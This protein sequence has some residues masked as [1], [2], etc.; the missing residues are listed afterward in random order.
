[1]KIET[2]KERLD[3]VLTKTHKAT[4]KNL[5]LPVL[6]CFLFKT[7]KDNFK[8]VATNLE[9]GVEFEVPVKVIKNGEVAV[10]ADV[11]TSFVSNLPKEEK[12]II[13]HEGNVLKINTPSTSITIKTHSIDDFPSIP[14]VN[15]ESSFSLSPKSLIDGLRSVWSSSSSSSIKPELSSVFM[16][17]KADSVF[18]V[19]T[20]SFRLAEKSVK[21]VSGDEIESVLIPFKN[22][23]EII[24]VVENCLD[25]TVLIS[26]DKNQLSLSTSSGYLTSRLIDG[27]FP[28]YTQII[29]KKTTTEVIVLKD[30]LS[31]ALKI[32]NLFT[33]E[34][35]QVK[36]IISTEDKKILIETKNVHVGESSVILK[37]T[38]EGESISMS[39]NHKYL[40][41]VFQSI[42]TDSVSLSFSGPGHPLV[43]KGIGDNSFLYLVMPMNK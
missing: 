16:Y 4:G 37:G 39:F 41:D 5:S 34:F 15:Q 18:F 30:E 2:T 26:V 43:I 20:D 36:V 28:D 10:P 40:I 23:P 14:V 11:I 21:K 6:E 13:E 12:L 22:I 38:L 7:E 24:R 27:T 25:K 19:A 3:E 33:D 42:N 31:N 17:T 8:V 29:P 9:L 35:K 1:M 32:G